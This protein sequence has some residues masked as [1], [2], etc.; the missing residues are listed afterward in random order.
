MCFVI[1]TV[2]FARFVYFMIQWEVSKNFWLLL[3]VH[4]I[5]K[6]LKNFSEDEVKQHFPKQDF[7]SPSHSILKFVLEIF[8]PNFSLP[9]VIQLIHCKKFN[10]AD[11]L[12]LSKIGESQMLRNVSSRI[13]A[14]RLP[15]LKI[16]AT[17]RMTHFHW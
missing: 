7:K 15:W 8:S 14:P 2:N 5:N 4:F 1:T 16:N 12:F 10:F 13:L 17:I 3:C 9:D 11:D 6:H